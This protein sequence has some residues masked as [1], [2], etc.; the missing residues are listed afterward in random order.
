MK[1]LFAWIGYPQVA[2]YYRRDP[3]YA[4]TSKWNYWRLWN[5][6]LDGITSFSIAP[7]KIATYFGLLTALGAF[8]YA[9]SSS[10]KPSPSVNRSAAIRHSWW[11]CC[12]SAECN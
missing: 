10:T 6:A 11:W 1:G 5:F 12:F 4:G 8:A 9:V 2:V 7:L 3:R